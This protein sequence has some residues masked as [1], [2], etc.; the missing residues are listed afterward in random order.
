MQEAS[1][2]EK[3]LN[4][5]ARQY[6]HPSLCAI[7][8]DTTTTTSDNLREVTR[9]SVRE[10]LR[11]L[12]PSSPKP[13]AATLKD[14]NPRPSPK[15]LQYTL[16]SPNDNPY[17]LTDMHNFFPNAS[18]LPPPL[19][20]MSGAQATAIA[21]PP[22]DDE[23]AFLEPISRSSF[24]QQQLSDPGLKRLT[25][26]LEGKNNQ[27]LSAGSDHIVIE[28][29]VVRYLTSTFEVPN[30]D[31]GTFM[32]NA[33][34]QHEEKTAIV[35]GTSGESCTFAELD[36]Q[37]RSVA[38]GLKSLGFVPGD[39]ATFVSV[40]S[41]DQLVA[42][43]GAIFAGAKV[44]F[45][46]TS[47][48]GR[49]LE[50]QLAKMSPSVVFCDSENSEKV[51]AASKKLTTVKAFVAFGKCNDMLEFS[52]LKN[53]PC[54]QTEQPAPRDP[55]DVLFVFYTSG[56]TGQPKGALITHRNFVAQV[57]G[58]ASEKTTFFERDVY[59]GLLPFAHPLGLCVTC[60]QMVNGAMTVALRTMGIAS[61][62]A[63]CGKYKNVMLL[64][65]PTYVRYLIEVPRP[66]KLDLSGVRAILIGGN[67]IPTKHI[68]RLSEMFPC[69]DVLCGYGLTEVAAA[70]TYCRVLCSDASCSGPPVPDLDMKVVDVI[71]KKKL[72]PD[73]CGEICI[74]GPITFKGYLDMPEETEKA[75]DKDGFFLTG[76]TGYY[77]EDGHFHVV[78]R[79]KD[80]IKCMDL[81]VAPVELE[82]LLLSHPDV[83]EVAVAGVPHAEFGEAARAFAVLR[84]GRR[85]DSAMQE[86][87]EEFVRGLVAFHKQLHGGIEFLST[88]PATETGKPLRRQLSEAYVKRTAAAANS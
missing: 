84:D 55:E 2:V 52:K 46:K 65:Y 37:G 25:E 50:S 19:Q 87:L 51:S 60:C 43:F 26:Y 56:T 59:M 47:L 54:D 15:P 85:G 20:S 9:E 86:S 76:D 28:D 82:T 75:F 80:L 4:V 70:A 30:V 29:G 41:L 10:E 53:G 22:G 42:L 63:A 27:K 61:L 18:S 21:P 36:R 71:T 62:L 40:N 74:R 31:F 8:P 64:L 83:R 69:A 13:H 33:W 17:V 78:G 45:E 23:D 81:Q 11:R 72:G 1:T 57:T 66:E 88:L 34:R 32:R 14:A 35:D 77:T 7:R 48:T 39:V 68:E 67:S 38:A 6:K 5:W 44:T 58:V 73:E 24:A 16:Y 12:M 3:T 49:E 79:I